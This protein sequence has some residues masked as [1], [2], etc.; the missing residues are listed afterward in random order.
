MQAEKKEDHDSID[1]VA[2]FL[3]EQGL[4]GLAAITEGENEESPKKKMKDKQKIRLSYD[5]NGRA[6]R[7]SV[8]NSAVT[9][10]RF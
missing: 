5:R 10:K 3:E 6:I 1:K 4:A 8:T 2:R 7:T 9:T